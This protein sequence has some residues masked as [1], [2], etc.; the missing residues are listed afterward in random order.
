[1][2]RS[3]W[4]VL[5]LGAPSLFLVACNPSSATQV[6]T[7]TAYDVST[8]ERFGRM[9]IVFDQVAPAKRDAFV[10]AHEGWGTAIRIVDLEYGGMRLVD[11]AH[12]DVSLTVSWQRPDEASL[13]STTLKQS[14]FHADHW[15]ITGETR[16]AGDTG[17]L[18]EPDP[19]LDSKGAAAK[20]VPRSHRAQTKAI[21]DAHGD[22]Q[23]STDPPFASD[24]MGFPPEGR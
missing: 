20:P 3:F 5:L 10:S 13:R 14:W 8:A 21:Q 17:L 6:L 1:M 23:G 11:P 7:D 19:K 2:P 16:V 15:V 22:D 24:T 9:D 18:E 12:A 4:G